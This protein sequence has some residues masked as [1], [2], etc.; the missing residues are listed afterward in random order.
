LY[1]D[2]TIHP[3]EARIHGERTSSIATKVSGHKSN[4][5]NTIEAFFKLLN[6]IAGKPTVT[7]DGS[8]TKITSTDILRKYQGP[9]TLAPTTKLR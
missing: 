2:R 1:I 7:G 5:Q 3:T 4:T 6:K 8:N 9:K